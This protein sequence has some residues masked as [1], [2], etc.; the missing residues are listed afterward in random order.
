MQAATLSPTLVD[1]LDQSIERAEAALLRMQQADGHFVFELEA[2]VSIPAEYVIFHHLRAAPFR[3]DLEAKFA[4]YIRDRQAAH[5]GWPLFQD[6]AS[7]LSPSSFSA[8]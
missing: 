4:R 5:D 3:P 6:G 7:G 2:D 1:G 8:K